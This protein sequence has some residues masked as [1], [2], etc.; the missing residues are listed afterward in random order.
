MG[1]LS[2]FLRLKLTP[3]VQVRKSGTN[4]GSVSELLAGAG[5]CVSFPTLRCSS[6]H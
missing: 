5:L 4:C 1:L 6:G 3:V 2:R